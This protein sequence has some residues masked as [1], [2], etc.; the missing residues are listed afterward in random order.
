MAT[1]RE[2][3]GKAMD[4]K[5]VANEIYLRHSMSVTEEQVLHAQAWLQEE[6]KLTEPPPVTEK[7]TENTTSTTT[8]STKSEANSTTSTTPPTMP[9]NVQKVVEKVVPATPEQRK[10]ELIIPEGMSEIPPILII[11]DLIRRG[12]RDRDDLEAFMKEKF[13][14]KAYRKD[15][16]ERLALFEARQTPFNDIPRPQDTTAATTSSTTS[17][18]MPTPQNTRVLSPSGAVPGTVPAVVETLVPAVVAAV[19][20]QSTDLPDVFKAAHALTDEQAI[21]DCTIAY[22]QLRVAVSKLVSFRKRFE[23][24]RCYSVPERFETISTQLKPT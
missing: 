17:P 14:G 7:K 12:Y 1:I 13:K 11:D 15:V 24:A 18:T 5:A 16:L 19:S 3:Q 4:A 6:L 20:E 2:C 10:I 9:D 8:V 23:T 22:Q 21:S